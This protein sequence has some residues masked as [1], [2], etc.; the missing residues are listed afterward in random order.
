LNE[1]APAAIH[2][3]V[4]TVVEDS[5][6][7]SMSRPAPVT[8]SSR[9]I[10]HSADA[11]SIQDGEE[12]EEAAALSE[13]VSRHFDLD[14]SGPIPDFPFHNGADEISETLRHIINHINTRKYSQ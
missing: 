11:M 1:E 6:A 3:S 14:I 8:P 10:S 5:L 4:E 13:T 12:S 9:E 7:A 2:Q